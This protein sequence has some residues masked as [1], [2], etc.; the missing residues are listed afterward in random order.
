MN[1]SLIRSIALLLFALVI[2]FG[3]V[4]LTMFAN[5]DDS[6]GGMLIGW[7]VVGGAVFIGAQAFQRGER[8]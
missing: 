7:V 1:L 3:G 5:A 8:A 4:M 6:P 2:A